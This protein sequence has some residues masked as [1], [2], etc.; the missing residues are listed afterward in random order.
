[1]DRLTLAL[2]PAYAVGVLVALGDIERA[3][4]GGAEHRRGDLADPAA[5][6]ALGALG[7]DHIAL[8]IAPVERDRRDRVEEREGV[9]GRHHRAVQI[10]GGDF[11]ISRPL[12]ARPLKRG[13]AGADQLFDAE[14]ADVFARHFGLAGVGWQVHRAL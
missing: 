13:V 7:G 10:L 11:D 1:A 2:I 5:H 4:E 3:P 12:L 9:A 6:A 8:H 14:R